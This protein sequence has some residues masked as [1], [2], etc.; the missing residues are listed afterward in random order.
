M[1][2][3]SNKCGQLG[4]RLF[5]FAHLIAAA[6]ENNFR[7][8]NLS[9]DEYAKY[10]QFT[11]QDI[12]CR[13]PH[14]KSYL[15]SDNVRS[16]LFI[17]NKAVVKLLRMVRF[18]NGPLHGM[19]IADLPEYQFTGDKFYNLKEKSFLRKAAKKKLLFLFG[20][21]FRDYEG[22]NRH[23]EA[24]KLFFTPIQPIRE[25]VSLFFQ[26]AKV[27]VDLVII[28]VHVRRGDYKVFAEG[29][30][31]YSLTE[32]F[33]KMKELQLSL[34]DRKV[35]FIICSNE[36]IDLSLFDGLDV[37]KGPGHIVEDMY[38]LAMCDYIMGP[39]STYTLWASFYGGKPLCRLKLID[40][41]L[42]LKDFEILP[43]ETLYNFSFN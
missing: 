26:K 2:V 5:A 27:D 39:P 23:Q 28:G 32:Y 42:T 24:V 29:K 35:K 30:Y 31:F 22:L 33:D 6:K 38:V 13:Y 18:Y 10:F 9:F 20:R 15:T 14:V 40:K 12:L 36:E 17:L 7:I 4:N 21:F 16:A 19:V 25:N 1:L 8:V 41:K 34:S 43:P 11:S 3:L 37:I